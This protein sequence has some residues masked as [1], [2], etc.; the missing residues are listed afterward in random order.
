MIKDLNIVNV[1]NS[2]YK[3]IKKSA[4]PV[5][6][7]VAL[8]LTG[9]GSKRVEIDDRY[10]IGD[11]VNA[12]SD[13]TLMDENLSDVSLSFDDKEYCFEDAH[14]W[15][16]NSREESYGYGC[17][18]SLQL[19][20]KMV[21]ISRIFDAMGID[22]STLKDYNVDIEGKTAF[23]TYTVIK[24]KYV[25][26]GIEV[27]YDE[28]ITEKF[29]L[30]GLAENAAINYEHAKNR[31][32]DFEHADGYGLNLNIDNVYRSLCRFAAGDSKLKSKSIHVSEPTNEEIESYGLARKR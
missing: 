2:N 21:I 27:S 28:E 8:S 7:A 12:R 23:V 16:K 15:Y 25:P 22:V 30:T 32:L 5:A 17:N 10:T 20:Y 13:E 14:N 6:I 9:C 24:K 19:L 29:K 11:V 18:A 1:L 4:A 31:A 26:G 3:L